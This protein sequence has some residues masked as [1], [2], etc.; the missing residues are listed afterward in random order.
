MRVSSGDRAQD[1]MLR[2]DLIGT[3]TLVPVA[4]TRDYWE[5][6]WLGGP[7][8]AKVAQR[9]QQLSGL[10]N[11]DCSGYNEALCGEKSCRQAPE[12][13]GVRKGSKAP[14]ARR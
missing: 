10:P 11:I 3:R 5:S 14:I 2:S 9:S 1:E 7:T 8:E 13:N 12:V 6:R 4:W